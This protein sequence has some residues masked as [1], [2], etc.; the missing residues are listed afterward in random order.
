MVTGQE[1]NQLTVTSISQ[2][3]GQHP[4]NDPDSMVSFVSYHHLWLWGSS[5]MTMRIF[6]WSSELCQMISRW[7]SCPTWGETLWKRFLNRQIIQGW[8][9]SLSFVII[10]HP[11]DNK[12]AIQWLKICRERFVRKNT[13][14]RLSTNRSLQKITNHD[15]NYCK[16]KSEPN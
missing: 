9:S 6:W 8:T 16:I 4:G 7:L 13:M 12:Q 3:S 15:G 5:S 2:L 10:N 1:N 11:A 14:E